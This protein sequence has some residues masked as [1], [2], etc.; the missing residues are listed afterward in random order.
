MAQCFW[1]RQLTRHERKIHDQKY[2]NQY[3]EHTNSRAEPFGANTQNMST[4]QKG[5]PKYIF[6]T[7]PKRDFTIISNSLLRNKTLSHKARG[8]LFMVLSHAPTWQVYLSSLQGP[9][10]GGRESIGKGM[11]ELEQ[12][13]YTVFH[14][15][16]ESGKFEKSY[17]TFHDE[18]VDEKKRT[19]RTQWKSG[20]WKPESWKPCPEKPCHGEPCDGESCDG[21]PA[22]KKTKGEKINKKNIKKKKMAG[23]AGASSSSSLFGNTDANVPDSSGF[24]AE[25]GNKEHEPDDDDVEHDSSKK[26]SPKLPDSR[27]SD[28][29]EKEKLL[30]VLERW[31]EVYE[32][33]Q[34]SPYV[35]SRKDMEALFHLLHRWPDAAQ[36]AGVIESAFLLVGHPKA[37][38]CNNRM[39]T[40]DAFAVNIA[41]IMGE[42]KKHAPLPQAMRRMELVRRERLWVAH[43]QQAMKYLQGKFGA[44]VISHPSPKMLEFLRGHDD[45][46]EVPAY[47]RCLLS[48]KDPEVMLAQGAA[49]IGEL[50]DHNIEG[51][52]EF[53]KYR[54]WL[55]DVAQ[56]GGREIKSPD[57]VQGLS[58]DESSA[59][60]SSIHNAETNSAS[61]TSAQRPVSDPG[62]M[63][64]IPTEWS[65]GDVD[66]PT[67]SAPPP[68][69]ACAGGLPEASRQPSSCGLGPMPPIPLQPSSVDPGKMP[70]IPPSH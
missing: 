3:S 64:P 34:G 57:D 28:A 55:I 7:N 9:K 69:S 68:T 26:G 2:S 22:P 38:T 42:V 65:L 62:P 29:P 58:G 61:I 17:W 25:N 39:E 27:K 31:R 1:A 52:E 66:A 4:P 14:E 11:R 30:P 23:S 70:P 43:H 32:I 24:A 35:E 19:N 54:G 8:M 13:G 53:L 60:K 56:F 49:A 41:K 16:R 45:R 36:L 15:E 44:D 37:W 51:F 63:P 46:G 47:F 59:E 21:K 20:N 6:R 33:V 10:L 18:P 40:I 12:A 5:K 48:H 50:D 67:L